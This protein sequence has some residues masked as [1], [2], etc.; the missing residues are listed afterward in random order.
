VRSFTASRYSFGSESVGNGDDFASI[1]NHKAPLNKGL[2]TPELV[3][4]RVPIKLS[5]GRVFKKTVEDLP[6]LKKLNLIEQFYQ[7]GSL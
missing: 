6:T 7:Q 5:P 2:V 1:V 3:T 4:K